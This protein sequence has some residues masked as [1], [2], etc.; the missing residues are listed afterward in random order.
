MDNDTTLPYPDDEVSSSCSNMEYSTP[1]QGPRDEHNQQQNLHDIAAV[2][3]DGDDEGEGQE[4]HVDDGQIKAVNSSGY[5]ASDSSISSGE[6]VFD[7]SLYYAKQHQQQQRLYH[8]ASSMSLSPYFK[9]GIAFAF[10]CAIILIVVAISVSLLTVDK[11]SNTNTIDQG[12]AGNHDSEQPPSFPWSYEFDNDEVDTS[13][14]TKVPTSTPTHTPPTS[15]PTSNPT[16]L[17][18]SSPTAFGATYRPGNLTTIKDGLLLS[19]GLDVRIIAMENE[20]VTYWN[21]TTSKSKFHERPDGGDTFDDTRE[22]NLGGWVYVSN[23]EVTEKKNQGG[24]GAFTFNKNGQLINYEMVLEDSTWNCGGGKTPWNTWVSC[25]EVEFDGLIYQV[26]PYGI[27]E[28]EVMTLGNEGGRWES[29]A[30]DVRNKD[31]PH[32][33]ATEDHNKGTVR[34]FTPREPDWVNDPWTMLHGDGTTDYLMISPNA[35]NNGGT[36]QWTNDREAAR[37]N[38]REFYPQTEGIDVYQN[39]MYFVCKNI[40]QIFVLDLDHGTYWNATTV[41]GMFDGK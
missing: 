2:A 40:R 5:T 35:T 41:N 8:D 15:M 39:E 18:T 26:D 12:G 28:A 27:R 1:E 24:V 20:K 10:A 33:F 23:S 4:L 31:K 34:R 21:G 13:K 11:K 6:I 22:W 9:K 7:E 29:F 37:N 38:A 32:F 17:P 36:F 30:Y 25:E 14:N 3:T 19:E 16:N